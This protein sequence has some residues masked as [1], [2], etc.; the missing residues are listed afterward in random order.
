MAVIGWCRS[1]SITAFIHAPHGGRAGGRTDRLHALGAFTVRGGAPDRAHLAEGEAAV[2]RGKLYIAG[3]NAR[4]YLQKYSSQPDLTLEENLAHPSEFFSRSRGH[5]VC[6]FAG[7]RHESEGHGVHGVWRASGDHVGRH[8]RHRVSK[9]PRMLGGR[10][11]D[12]LAESNVRLLENTAERRAMREAARQLIEQRYS[13]RPVVDKMM[14]VY[15]QM[16]AS[17]AAR[18][19][20]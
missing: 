4:K 10:D 17:S 19:S 7:Q 14:T 11:D 9:W 3:W 18:P 8:G 20:A 6:A 1:R 13:P 15:Q 5:G 16:I 12:E 2:S